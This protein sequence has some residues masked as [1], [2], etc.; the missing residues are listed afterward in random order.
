MND[1]VLLGEIKSGLQEGVAAI[2]PNHNRYRI[3]L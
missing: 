2:S 1:G 3:A